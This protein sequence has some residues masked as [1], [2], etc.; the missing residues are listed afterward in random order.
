MQNILT[1]MTFIPLAGAAVVL[2]LPN[3]AKLVR[4]FSAI[5]TVPPLL[6]A[7]WLFNNFDRT[8]AKFQFVEDYHWI[9][10]Y[11]ISYTAKDYIVLALEWG[12]VVYFHNAAGKKFENWTNRAGFGAAGTGW[13]NS[14]AAADLNGDGRLDYVAG[15]TGLNTKYRASIIAVVTF[16]NSEG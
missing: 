13:W 15:N 16:T 10:A 6:M 5:V 4:W 11:N 14:L 8:T 9:P 7:I 2:A 3:N 1:Y 12:N